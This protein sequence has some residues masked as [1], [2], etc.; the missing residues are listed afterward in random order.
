MLLNCGVGEDSWES[1]GLQEIQPVHPKEDQSWVFIGRTDAETETPV[2]WPPH[3]K[4]WLIG[5]D[6]DAGKDWVQEEKG[7]TEMRWLDDN[8]NSMD[9]GLGGL[10][11]LMMDREAWYAAIHGVAKSRTWLSN[12]TELNWAAKD[13]A[14]WGQRLGV[15]RFQPYQSL[16]CSAILR[17]DG[18]PPPT[19]VLWHPS[20]H[21]WTSTL[22]F[23]PVPTLALNTLLGTTEIEQVFKNLIRWL[24]SK[25]LSSFKS[26]LSIHKHPWSRWHCVSDTNLTA[27]SGAPPPVTVCIQAALLLS[28]PLDTLLSFPSLNLP[29]SVFPW[30]PP[31]T[32]TLGKETSSSFWAQ[33]SL[34]SPGPLPW[35]LHKDI[36]C[37]T[38]CSYNLKLILWLQE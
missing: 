11:E 28:S 17:T 30:A 23:S 12:W 14:A 3:V 5:K 27:S 26:L 10:W 9:M 37:S 32:T 36:L 25:H 4:S 13:V 20:G 29:K 21:C 24:C 31:H 34:N 7:T 8:T 18:H 15:L 38:C 1:L 16:L 19:H 2:L 22:P 6:P 33:P 35:P